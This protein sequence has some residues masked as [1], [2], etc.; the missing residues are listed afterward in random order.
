MAT[1][2]QASQAAVLPL[3]RRLGYRHPP[4]IPT[5]AALLFCIEELNCNNVGKMS[6]IVPET[7]KSENT[8]VG[9]S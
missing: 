9:E 1:A 3:Q 5:P 4:L 2:G 6:K 8:E 7:W